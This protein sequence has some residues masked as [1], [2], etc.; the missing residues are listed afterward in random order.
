MD[1]RCGTVIRSMVPRDHKIAQEEAAKRPEETWSNCVYKGGR[2]SWICYYPWRSCL[3][4]IMNYSYFCCI[5]IKY[6]MLYYII[7]AYEML[8]LAAV[9]RWCK[10]FWPLKK[11]RWCFWLR[12]GNGTSSPNY[13]E[14]IR[15]YIS[16]EVSFVLIT[17]F[18]LSCP[19]NSNA[20]PVFSR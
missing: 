7:F 11:K 8:W 4:S 17:F 2:S 1:R 15:G 3:S 6:I 16:I 12:Y 13:F 18:S 20:R 9:L 14:I 10:L 19:I 5:Y